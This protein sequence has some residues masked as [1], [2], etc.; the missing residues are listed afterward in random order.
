MA[1]S[2]HWFEDKFVDEQHGVF[3]VASDTTKRYWSIVVHKG[4]ECYDDFENRLTFFNERSS[5]W[6]NWAFIVH[7]KDTISKKEYEQLSAED[8]ERYLIKDDGKNPAK[9]ALVPEH[10]HAVLAFEDLKSWSRIKKGFPG[11]HCMV[12]QSVGS[13][14]AYLT[15]DTKRAIEQGKYQ[16]SKSE[17][18]TNNPDYF[19]R[20]TVA[21]TVFEVF[22]P[23]LLS[24]YV[25]V[26]GCKNYIDFVNR[27]SIVQVQKWLAS[28][29]SVCNMR[30][31]VATNCHGKCYVM[32]NHE[33]KEVDFFT[34]E[35]I[36]NGQSNE[37]I[38]C[39]I[40]PYVHFTDFGREYI[41]A[42]LIAEENLTQFEGWVLKKTMPK[43]V[44]RFKLNIPELPDLDK[45][46]NSDYQPDLLGFTSDW[47]VSNNHGIANYQED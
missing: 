13:S 41:T 36:K 17:I 12:C 45:A 44:E 38:F 27:F 21:S 15:H 4:A 14:F 16:Y 8:Q 28:I 33:T 6:F 46:V 31:F 40:L 32:F 22:D 30:D 42:K 20:G 5:R 39:E 2:T 47:E 43:T 25:F 23:H 29:N 19:M 11:A 7:N 26:D 1:N 9:Y 35:E 18:V 37:C 24:K 3:T 34:E 10:I